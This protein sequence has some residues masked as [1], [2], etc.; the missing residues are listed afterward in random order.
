MISSRIRRASVLI[1][2][3]PLFQGWAEWWGINLHFVNSH[4]TL[5]TFVDFVA[6][7]LLDFQPGTRWMYSGT[8]GLDVIARI[9]EVTSGQPF[10]VFVQENIF[11]PLDMRDPHWWN[12]SPVEKQSQFVVRTDSGVK[13]KGRK[14]DAATTK[15]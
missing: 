9:I 14:L 2:W 12:D 10:N 8:V 6:E 1:G 7:A 15:K 4:H 13:D 11:N 5:E 3:V